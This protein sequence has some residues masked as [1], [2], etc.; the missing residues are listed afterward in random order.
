MGID[1]KNLARLSPEERIKKLK[2]MEDERKKEVG[3]IEALIRQSIEEMRTDK[4]A[5][6]VAPPQ[7]AVDISRLFEAGGEQKLERTAREESFTPAS[8]KGSKSYRALAQTYEDYSQ[9]KRLYGIVAMGG[10]LTEEHRAAISQISE[11]INVAEKYMTEG[12]K[13]A[14]KLDPSR[15][16]LYK[17]KKETGL[18]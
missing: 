11:R 9:L 8:I 5:E 13:T 18:G 4:L 15:A 3:E 17:L 16:I 10:S 2:L 12:E 6:E 1:K 7:R 14:S